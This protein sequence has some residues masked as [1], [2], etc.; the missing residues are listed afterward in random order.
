MNK[1][2]FDHFINEN[3]HPGSEIFK[4][5]QVIENPKDTLNV[6]YWASN[7]DYYAHP[8]KY[9]HL[10]LLNYKGYRCCQGVD[11]NDLLKYMKR[12]RK[13]KINKINEGTM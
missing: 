7:R 10:D 12:L 5:E 9:P 3:S 6:Y 8:E 2:V 4:F 1:E 11:K 13:Q